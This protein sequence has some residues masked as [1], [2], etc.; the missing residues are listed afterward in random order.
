MTVSLTQFMLVI[1]NPFV[2][3]ISSMVKPNGIIDREKCFDLFRIPWV[4]TPRH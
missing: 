3:V 2:Q 4:E 1:E